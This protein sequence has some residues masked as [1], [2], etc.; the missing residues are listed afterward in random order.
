MKKEKTKVYDFRKVSM[1]VEFDIFHEVDL[2]HAFGNAIHQNTDDIG[3]DE[4]ARKIFKEDTVEISDE[5]VK[6]LLLM[7][8]TCKMKLVIAAKQALIKVLEGK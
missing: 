2:R 7:L 6:V 3:I 8:R 5:D 1:E 4:V